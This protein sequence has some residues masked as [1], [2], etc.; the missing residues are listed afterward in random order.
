[1]R[2]LFGFIC[3]LALGL[4]GRRG[5]SVE[6]IKLLKRTK[7][8]RLQGRIIL[9]LGHLDS[10]TAVESSKSLN[11]HIPHGPQSGHAVENQ[12]RRGSVR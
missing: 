6:L 9:A 7:S 2:Y 10:A 8:T 1:M 5:V 4:M 12:L 3:M 11:V